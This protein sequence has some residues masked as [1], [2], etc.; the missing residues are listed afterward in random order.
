MDKKA[1]NFPSE[2]LIFAFFAAAFA[3]QLSYLTHHER[4]DVAERERQRLCD[5]A[6]VAEYMLANQLETIDT[7]LSNIRNFMRL[8]GQ[9]GPDEN[10]DALR[11]AGSRLKILT[12]AMTS[13][14]TLSIV[15]ARGTIVTS[16]LDEIVGTNAS[17]HDYFMTPRHNPDPQILFISPP[18]KNALG[19]W[20]INV[21]RVITADDG[22]FVGVVTATLD[23]E[24]FRALMNAVRYSE[25]AWVRIVHGRGIIFIWAPDRLNMV[26]TNLAKPETFFTRH[27]ES[28]Q[29]QSLFQGRS[30]ST[31][32]DSLLVLHT[33]NS[34]HL[35][36]NV[37]LVLG[38][39]RDTRS[40]YAD[41]RQHIQTYAILYAVMTFTGAAMLFASQ[42]W[43]LHSRREAEH[44]GMRLHSMQRELESFFSISPNLLTIGDFD[45][46]CIKLNPAWENV[47]GYAPGELDGLHYL[48]FFH[49]D[50]RDT[51][52]SILAALKKGQSITNFVARFR[53]KQGTYRYLEW[54]AAAYEDRIY[55][56]ASDIT[57]R[58]ETEI[59]MHE[60]AYYDRLTG[61]PNRMLFFDR[62]AQTLLEAKRCRKHAAIL[63]VDLDGFKKVNDEYGHDAGDTVLKTIAKRFPP[64]LRAS[65]TVARMGGDEFVI[66]LHELEEITDAHLVAQKL[67]NAVATDII[68]SPTEKCRVGASI[69]IS[70]Y[71]EHGKDMDAL[72]MAADMA[73]YASKKKGA[74]R[75]AIAGDSSNTE[76]EIV[77]DDTYLTGV[78]E[79][80]EQH[81]ELTILTN[82][83]CLSLTNR[84]NEPVIVEC[85][86]KMVVAFT[87]Y[88]FATEH[89]L[90][91]QHSYPDQSEHDTE[92]ERLLE[93]LR[94][95]GSV[96]AEAESQFRIAYLRKWLQDHILTQDKALGS[97][98]KEIDTTR[99]ERTPA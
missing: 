17:Q 44:M 70:I 62:L 19:E 37:P 53:H 96:M 87:E 51:G 25:N 86:F 48:D 20:I 57:D 72:L 79:I 63:F 66:L 52:E 88:H 6:S 32:E 2:W 3:C 73:M 65:D 49:P 22:S 81:K 78:R 1:D 24:F 46:K 98:L 41:W 76:E 55:S 36:M 16:N 5:V 31:N 56:A 18:Y 10:P 42:R 77:L 90:M 60:L 12:G 50:D 95:F 74:N 75:Y 38:F 83:L 40:I 7:T 82:R 45:G 64:T 58:R 34:K 99:H 13:V 91:R 33:V 39:G 54:S 35:K 97:F 8:P 27:L 94:L 92:H 11:N 23:S 47:M 30:Y 4:E 9:E 89:K 80:D 15:D 14:R 67:L 69:G 29:P 21:S 68:L 28:G 59:R 26:G 93:E 85:L 71:P 43:R 84:K 61:L